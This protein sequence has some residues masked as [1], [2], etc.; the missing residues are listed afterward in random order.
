MSC[1]LNGAEAKEAEPS[2]RDNHTLRSLVHPH[3]F[4]PLLLFGN[5]K[6]VIGALESKTDNDI[7]EKFPERNDRYLYVM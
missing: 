7:K 1:L 5:L 4:F 6:V 3:L 2:P